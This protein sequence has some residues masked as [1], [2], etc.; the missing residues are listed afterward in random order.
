[1]PKNYTC[2]WKNENDF[3]KDR[4][5]FI[6]E[7]IPKWKYLATLYIMLLQD[8]EDTRNKIDSIVNEYIKLNREPKDW[9]ID[10]N[11]KVDRIYF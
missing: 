2:F 1:M 7:R 6:I 11:Y 4:P 8:D 3:N 9:V 10:F 5:S